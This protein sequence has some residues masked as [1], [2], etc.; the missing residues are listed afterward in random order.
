MA[1]LFL[2]VLNRSLT[3]SYV[4]TVVMLARVFLKKAPKSISYLL[5]A[6][7]G[8]RLLFPFSIQSAFSLVPFRSALISKDFIIHTAPQTG[9]AVQGVSPAA[10]GALPA[11]QA[12]AGES[13]L[14]MWLSVGSYLWL[15]G[16]IA[17]LLY[18][19]VT[20]ILLKR[21]LRRAV[22]LRDNIYQAENIRTPFVLGFFRPDI[23]IPAG[24][25]R[26]EMS[27][28]ILHEQTHIRRRD[29]IV[30]LLGYLALCLHWFNPLAWAAFFLMGADME[31]S[32]DE[33]V[34]KQMGSG[35]KRAYSFSLLSLSAKQRIIGGSPL[36]FGEGGMK[37]RIKNILHFKKRSRVAVLLAFLFA[38]VLSI[39]FAVNQTE[40]PQVFL[41]RAD[42][43]GD[44]RKETL[45]LDTSRQKNGAVVLKIE[46]AD[47]KEIWAQDALTAHPG[48]NSLFLYE[49]GGKQ[50]LLRYTPA[51]T[52]GGGTYAYCIFRLNEHGGEEIVRKDQVAFHIYEAQTLDVDKMAG[53]AQEVNALLSKSRLLLSS[54]GG[55]FSFGLSPADPYFETYSWLDA[56]P[57]LY[58]AG[59]DL[60]T[61]LTKYRESVALK[62][63]S[64][65]VPDRP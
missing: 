35:I 7:V 39:G 40:K 14:Q 19:V 61:R 24:L 52:Q 54:E 16:V 13:T 57:Q 63:E 29:P 46:D 28:I 37:E 6:V 49:D 48:W 51:M 27:Y 64:A 32:C 10:N 44:S 59:D 31:M 60:K 41:I 33:R 11:A 47:D 1:L 18:S 38:A 9:A 17:M 2:S 20:I 65:S 45:L 4:I 43:G 30:K 36:A 23:Y 56:T 53:F 12:A 62:A 55:K 50:Y 15:A 26:Q 8:F 5:W 22:L 25:E 42:V 58:G 34:L 3:A 21:R